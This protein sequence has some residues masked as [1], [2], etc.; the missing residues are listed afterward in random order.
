[1]SDK[2]R[3]DYNAGLIPGLIIITIGLLFFLERMDFGFAVK[4]RDYWPLL[5]VILG[6]GLLI[7][8]KHYR[9]PILGGT[10]A[11]IGALLLIRNLGYINFKFSDIWP[12]GIIAVGIWLI[13][14]NFWKPIRKYR[15]DSGEWEEVFATTNRT[16]DSDFLKVSSV[17]GS[18]EYKINNK[19][20]KGGVA[21]TVFGSIDID[22]RDADMEQ[23]KI[24]F[25]AN[26]VFGAI[27]L[28]VPVD[29]KV[30]LYGSPVLGSIE[31]K[32]GRSKDSNKKLTVKAASVFG[33]VEIRN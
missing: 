11:V 32:T 25:K 30:I 28:K 27:T 19:K 20:F 6:A 22:L 24:M 31:D 14:R 16:I 4:F 21:D 3:K 33:S 2:K 10:L 8:P 18:G 13:S 15:G 17:F 1:M 9:H 12:L 23:D 5:L 7:R 26:S 29:W